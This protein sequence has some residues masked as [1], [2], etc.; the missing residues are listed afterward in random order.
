M[1]GPK[2]RHL[3]PLAAHAL[4]KNGFTK[5]ETYHNLMTAHFILDIFLSLCCHG[6]DADF[7]C[8]SSLIIAYSST[9]RKCTYFCRSYLLNVTCYMK[10]FL[11]TILK[12][13]NSISYKWNLIH[14]LLHNSIKFD[15]RKNGID[16][17]YFH[18]Q[19]L[20]YKLDL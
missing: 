4:L 10:R 12:S 8:I 15:I 20:Y 3:A 6:Q 17:F 13:S 7:D 2:F 19:F 5:D 1:K 11:Q 14:L 9:I 18:L 16:L